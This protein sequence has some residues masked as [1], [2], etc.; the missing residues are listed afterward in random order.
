MSPV[1]RAG[2][3]LAHPLHPYSYQYLPRPQ[4]C[5]MKLEGIFFLSCHQQRRGK[6]SIRT[7]L[8]L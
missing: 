7:D 6:A 3:T 4:Q 5:K 8:Y 2:V 1:L